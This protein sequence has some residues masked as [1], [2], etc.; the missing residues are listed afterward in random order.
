VGLVIVA[1]V[2]HLLSFAFSLFAIIPGI[3]PLI[4][5]EL[6]VTDLVGVLFWVGFEAARDKGT[7]SV[8]SKA[9]A[10]VWSRTKELYGYQF[11]ILK[12]G[13]SPDNLRRMGRKLSSWFNG[14]IPDVAHARGEIAAT[15]CMG[16][17]LAG[18]YD[19]FKGP[20]GTAFIQAIRD[21]F[22]QL[23][24]VP[25]SGIADHM[26]SYDAA[27]MEGV[28]N[29]VKGRMFELLIIEAEN[30]DGDSITA[31]SE[32]DMSQPA[33]D[34]ILKNNQTGEA[35][36]IQLKATDSPS[37]IEHALQRYPDVPILTTEEVG[38]HFAGSH[39][40]TGSAI[41]NEH[42]TA[43]T[44]DNFERLVEGLQPLNAAAMAAAGSATQAT[45]GL[46]P[47]V[48]ARLRGQITEDQM[49]IA[50]QKVLGEA[51][52]S[53]ASRVSYA[54]VFGPVFAWYLLARGILKAV[55]AGQ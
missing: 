34:L 5:A 35:V 22:P 24:E 55:R 42:L 3:N 14:E 26:R 31:I 44:Q 1:G 40:V 27:Q 9:L 28:V 6:F 20:L 12:R 39:M 52:V 50:F 37:Y 2:K 47:F 38:E 21:R 46:W 49:S 43:V 29:E 25:I 23:A 45:I 18:H 30:S 41:G 15:A 54:V 16:W 19:A 53:L 4:P 13:L 32:G 36:A 17:L 48:A 51:G 10:Q 33:T 7:F 11:S 8:P